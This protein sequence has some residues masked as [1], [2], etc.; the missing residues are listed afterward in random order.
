MREKLPGKKRPGVRLSSRRDIA[1]RANGFNWQQR[2]QPRK[3]SGQGL[4]LAWLERQT[5]TT[6]QL[7]AKREIVAALTPQPG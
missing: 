2:L 7:Y 6:F 3:Q 5:V 1:M 4:V